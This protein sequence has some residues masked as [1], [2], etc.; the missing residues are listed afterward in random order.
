MENSLWTY[1][2]NKTKAEEEKLSEILHNVPI[3]DNLNKRDL[4]WI[5]KNIHVRNYNRNEIVFAEDE[6]GVGLYI[7]VK[8]SVRISKKETDG[9]DITLA[10]LDSGQFFGELSLLDDSPRSATAI[11]TEPSVLLGFFHPDLMSL[12]DRRP[13]MGCRILLRLAQLLGERL[14]RTN[15]LLQ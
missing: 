7:I 10:T 2:F 3:F 15:E 4:A 9:E 14:R 12:I 1:I 13:N 11:T 6:P 5:E 8:G